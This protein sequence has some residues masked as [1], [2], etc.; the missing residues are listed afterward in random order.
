MQ[1]SGRSGSDLKAARLTDS[2]GKVWEIYEGSDRLCLQGGLGKGNWIVPDMD[3]LEAK[4]K[5]CTLLTCWLCSGNGAQ[6]LSQSS[7]CSQPWWWPCKGLQECSLVSS[8][9]ST[10]SNCSHT[11][12]NRPYQGNSMMLELRPAFFPHVLLGKF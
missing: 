8:L 12:S 1:K 10:C 11:W 9:L 2:E 4:I 7:F 6:S 3:S 5:L